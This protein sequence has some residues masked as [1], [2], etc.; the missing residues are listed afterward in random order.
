MRV[1]LF[2]NNEK[3]YVQIQR[4][5]ERNGRKTLS[6]PKFIIKLCLVNLPMKIRADTLLEK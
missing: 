4:D 5:G 3:I 6:L 1:K 2:I